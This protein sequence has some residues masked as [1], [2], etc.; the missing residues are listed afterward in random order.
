MYFPLDHPNYKGRY[1]P[2][3]RPARW[4]DIHHTL[5]VIHNR[6]PVEW[7][8]KGL[9]LEEPVTSLDIG[10]TAVAMAGGDAK[11]S[12][13]TDGRDSRRAVQTHDP[14]GVPA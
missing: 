5:P 11:S 6:E 13:A 14:L 3:K 9:V 7:D 1:N 10:A 12:F 2:L 8:C 4:R